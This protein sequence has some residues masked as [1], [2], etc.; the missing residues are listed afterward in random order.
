MHHMETVSREYT[1]AR[2]NA[3]RHI[4]GSSLSHISRKT[5]I[6]RVAISYFMNG[7]DDKLSLHSIA[8]IHDL[9]DYLDGDNLAIKSIDESDL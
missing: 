1:R 7:N 3:F 6:S 4:Y 2:V 9:L 8:K 5:G